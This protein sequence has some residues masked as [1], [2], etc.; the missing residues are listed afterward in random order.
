MTVWWSTRWT[1]HLKVGGSSLV[2]VVVLFPYTRNFIPRKDHLY[3]KNQSALWTISCIVVKHAV[4]VFPSEGRC[5]GSGSL[6]SRCFVRQESLLHIRAILEAVLNYHAV[7][8]RWLG[9][10]LG[11]YRDVASLVKKLTSTRLFSLNP[12]FVK[13]YQCTIRET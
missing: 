5:F 4:S 13:G 3:K 12:G 10:S 9:S 6:P 2:S 8:A 11:L 7:P 1:F